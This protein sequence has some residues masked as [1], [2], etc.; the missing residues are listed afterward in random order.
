MSARPMRPELCLTP[1]LCIVLAVLAGAA[2]LRLPETAPETDPAATDEASL[3]ELTE[4]VNLGTCTEDGWDGEVRTDA[5]AALEVTI[6]VI[7]NGF[8]SEELGSGST[9]VAVEPDT[10]TAFSVV[11]DPPISDLVLSCSIE[12]A[13]VEVRN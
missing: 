7:F 12:L 6:G 2:C 13:R 11:P 3:R 1:V 8:G 9:T 5:A 10:P 4:L